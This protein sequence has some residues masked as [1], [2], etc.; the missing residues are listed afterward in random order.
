MA[1]SF[2]YYRAFILT[3]LSLALAHVTASLAQSVP[4]AGQIMREL[5]QTSPGGSKSLSP[6]NPTERPE[7]G[8]GN[9][10]RITVTRFDI[11]GNTSISSDDLQD[12]L[13]DQLGRQL[14]L[15][16]LKSAASRLTA[17]YRERGFLV[18]RAYLPVQDVQGGKIKILILE[19]NIAQLQLRNTSSLSD[20]RAQAFLN[21]AVAGNVIRSDPIDRALLLLNDVPGI[22][23]VRA[24]LQPGSSVGTSD[25]V[26]DVEPGPRVTGSVGLDNYGSRYT[27]EKR[28]S[29]AFYIN[30]LVGIGDQTVVSGL[31]SDRKLGYGR[32][33]YSV[34]VGGNGLRV[35]TFVSSTKY[36]LA[37]EFA[38]LDAHGTAKNVSIYATYPL[39]RS[40]RANLTTSVS[41]ESRRLNDRID[42]IGATNDKKARVF[43]LGLSGSYRDDLGGGGLS[44]FDVSTNFGKLTIESPVALAIDDISAKTNGAYKKVFITGNRLQRIS[45]NDSLWLAL[46]A[47]WASKNL[48]SSE[49]FVLGGANGVRAYPQGEGIGDQGYLASVEYR[50][51]FSEALQAALFYDTGS[52][53]INREV[54]DSASSNKRTLS[55]MGLGFNAVLGGADLRASLAWRSGGEPLSVPVGTSKSPTLWLRANKPF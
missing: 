18:A 7:E 32:V 52:V 34:P 35:G 33:G 23:A 20:E 28:L 8:P 37:R 21:Q 27:G 45:D 30:N 46:S 25:L 12:V 54:F 3:S 40:Q 49:K 53:S 50:H 29:G 31:L 13:T 9:D 47:Q 55:G 44:N 48:D 5:R 51:N 14:S 26:V 2:R 15:S 19:G 22:G 11:E 4:D 10:V 39:V 16:D 24:T 38:V 17:L 43:G 41:L 42:A 36:E 6:A 1:K